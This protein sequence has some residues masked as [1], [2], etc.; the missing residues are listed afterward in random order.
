[1][2]KVGLLVLKQYEKQARGSRLGWFAGAEAMFGDFAGIISP[3]SEG[4]NSGYGQP[5]LSGKGIR[6]GGTVEGGEVRYRTSGV[7]K[8][9][10]LSLQHSLLA[11]RKIWSKI[12]GAEAEGRGK[13][14]G[15]GDGI[16]DEAGWC[17]YLDRES[18]PRGVSFWEA[19]R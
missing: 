6:G 8:N 11:C 10:E 4:C 19:K 2:R 7:Q 16:C 5:L 9:S 12:P 13:G 1:M 14:G 3:Y 18:A 17:N 15:R